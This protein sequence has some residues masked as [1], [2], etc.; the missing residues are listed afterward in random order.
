MIGHRANLLDDSK[1]ETE[2]SANPSNKKEIFKK[3]KTSLVIISIL[4]FAALVA[5]PSQAAMGHQS[6]SHD[7]CFTQTITALDWLVDIA[8]A[9]AAVIPG[10]PLII[11]GAIVAAFL[12]GQ[13][14]A[15]ACNPELIPP[16]SE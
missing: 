9:I 14:I 8:I 15:M 2:D 1:Q 4:L 10:G 11:F 6:S 7:F 3:P 12:G 5:F 13:G 16:P